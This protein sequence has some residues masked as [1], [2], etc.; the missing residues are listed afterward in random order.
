[1]CIRDS[2]NGTNRSVRTLS[3]GEAFKASLSLALGLSDEI[4]AS[5]G[6]LDLILFLWTKV[7]VH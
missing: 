5:A 6:E 2:Y 7:L 3:G 1:M 4:H